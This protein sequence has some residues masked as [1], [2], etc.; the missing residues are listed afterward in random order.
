[1]D[2]VIEQFEILASQKVVLGPRAE[3]HFDHLVHPVHEHGR[4]FGWEL[5]RRA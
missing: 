5:L 4:V 3:H 1:M 2:P